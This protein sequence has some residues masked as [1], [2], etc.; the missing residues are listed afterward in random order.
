MRNFA[1]LWQQIFI[2]SICAKKEN[3]KYCDQSEQIYFTLQL[4]LLAFE[5]ILIGSMQ[6]GQLI[7][8]RKSSCFAFAN[9]IVGFFS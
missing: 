9:C 6:I 5:L 8:G 3:K 1:W 4:N 7:G 2:K